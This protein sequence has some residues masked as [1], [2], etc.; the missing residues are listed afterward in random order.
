M[1]Q[2]SCVE[3]GLYGLTG[4]EVAMALADPWRL[5]LSFFQRPLPNRAE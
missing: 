1:P 3:H 2:R 4:V 5:I